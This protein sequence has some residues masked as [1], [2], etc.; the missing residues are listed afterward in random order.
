MFFILCVH[1]AANFRLPKIYRS[2]NASGYEMVTSV[3]SWSAS[4]YQQWHQSVLHFYWQC[5]DFFQ[6]TLFGFLQCSRFWLYLVILPHTLSWGSWWSMRL[7]WWTDSP[8]FP[9]MWKS[10]SSSKT[11]RDVMRSA[12]EHLVPCIF[13]TTEVVTH[14]DGGYPMT[15]L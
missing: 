15:F 11:C 12:D 7:V 4:S 2:K 13:C 8:P 6:C 10:S 14:R 5:I 3:G 1:M 9:C